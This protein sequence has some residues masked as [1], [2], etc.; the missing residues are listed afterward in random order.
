MNSD[1]AWVTIAEMSWL[2]E[3]QV[4]KTFLQSQG[5]DAFIPEEFI[6]TIN[7]M[8]TGICVRVQVRESSVEDAK[9]LLA[10]FKPESAKEKCPNCGSEDLHFKP[11]G[12]KGWIMFVICLLILVPMKGPGR[13]VCKSCGKDVSAPE[14]A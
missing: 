12:L 4:L 13:K 5:L 3:A 1:E 11:V 9:K 2:S 7:P 8:V 14:P 6:S 10:E